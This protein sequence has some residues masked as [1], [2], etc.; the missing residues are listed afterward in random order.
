MLCRLSRTRLAAP[1]DG[2]TD[3]KAADRKLFSTDRPFHALVSGLSSP[4]MAIASLGLPT[5]VITLGRPATFTLIWCDLLCGFCSIR[6][7]GATLVS[8]TCITM[9]C[10]FFCCIS[11]SNRSSSACTSSPLISGPPVDGSVRLGVTITQS[12]SSFVPLFSSHIL[13]TLRMPP[14]SLVVARLYRCE[15]AMFLLPDAMLRYATFSRLPIGSPD[16]C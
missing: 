11:F 7:G 2:L 15:M 6:Y 10:S 8:V 5:T 3:V 14:V 12:G 1:K 4:F 16:L 13:L 9:P